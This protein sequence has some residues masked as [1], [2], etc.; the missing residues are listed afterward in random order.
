M[1][2]APA[3]IET[4][5]LKKYYTGKRHIGR[6]PDVVKALDGV[7][8]SVCAGET[9]G[10]VG[11]S[12]CGK[13]T[14]GRTILRLIQ[15]TSGD[16]LYRGQSIMGLSEKEMR[17]MR[18]KLQMVF[19]DPYASL[20]PRMTVREIIQSPLDAF[21]LGTS[22][23]RLERVQQIMERVSLGPQMM[24]RYPHEFSGG[25]RQ[26]IV[27]AR[28]LILK[29]EFVVC[30]EPVSA[31]DVS[32]RSQVL[33]LMRELQREMNLAYLFI[34]H[35]LSV[36]RHISDRVAVMY[37]GHVVE[38]ADKAELFENPCHPYTKALMSAIPV[39]DVDCKKQKIILQGDIP[40]PINPPKGCPFHTRCPNAQPRCAEEKPPM[41]AV[42]GHHQ[43][44]CHLFNEKQEQE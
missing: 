36:V 44:A 20:N 27:I 39:P 12:G 29:P 7:S 19:Q 2:G 23:E 43:V 13:S 35:D 40:T 8:I 3:L 18:Q 1:S 16:V 15:A 33:N 22:A 11:E 9:L 42:S 17:F 31:L 5:D 25:Q 32:V 28:A 26:R 6:Q 37:L 34:S 24:E 4:V 30:D 38:L 41:T 21:R 10:V 14:L